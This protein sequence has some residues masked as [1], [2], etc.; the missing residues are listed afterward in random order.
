MTSLKKMLKEMP[1]VETLYIASDSPTSQYRN[2]KMMYLMKEFSK[3]KKTNIIWIFT[4]TGHGKGPMDGVGAA[5]KSV[6]CDTLAYNP[7]GVIRN[8]EQLMTFIPSMQNVQIMTYDE[9]DHT[10]CLEVLPKQI[11]NLK[12]LTR[13]GFGIKKVHEVVIPQS[14]ALLWKKKSE[15]KDYAEVKLYMTCAPWTAATLISD[16]DDSSDGILLNN[17]I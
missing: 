12:L 10:D 3:E 2:K 15:D 16:N 11:K 14:D 8:T 4:E 1:D 17:Y 9:D 7:N 13:C 6:I 5:V